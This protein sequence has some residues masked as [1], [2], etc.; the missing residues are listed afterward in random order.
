MLFRSEQTILRFVWNQKRPQ[1]ATAIFKNKTKP[2]GIT[3][4]DFKMYYK[5]VINTIVWYWH[6]NRHSDQWN[7]IQKPEMDSQ[8]YGQLIFD[9]AGKN[10]QRNKDSLFSKWC[11]GNWTGTCR[12]MHLDHFLTQYRKINSN[13][14]KDLKVFKNLRRA[15]R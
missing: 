4:P 5:A 6:M 2:G 14:I 7:T 13:W 1:I 11:W 10:V 3:I 15:H 12:K 9:K 8:T